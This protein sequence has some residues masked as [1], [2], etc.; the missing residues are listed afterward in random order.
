MSVRSA[1]VVDAL[2]ALK[3]VEEIVSQVDSVLA[4]ENHNGSDSDRGGAQNGGGSPASSSGP[5][6]PTALSRQQGEYQLRM[7]SRD[8]HGWELGNLET[9]GARRQQ[10]HVGTA[11]AAAIAGA[12]GRADG[13]GN[14]GAVGRYAQRQAASAG[15]ARRRPRTG[16][17][18][19]DMSRRRIRSANDHHA[20]IGSG[21]HDGGSFSNHGYELGGS[22]PAMSRSGGSHIEVIMV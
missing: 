16:S 20:R 22:A 17:G 8:D 10:D 18:S 5:A 9:A 2:T 12:A 15:G 21:G 7:W 13:G 11:A 4:A 14:V 6:S 3:T 1:G 19:H